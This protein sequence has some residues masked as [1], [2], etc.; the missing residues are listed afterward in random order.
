MGEPST[1]QEKDAAPKGVLGMMS[2]EDQQNCVEALKA[3]LD[4][5]ECDPHEFQEGAADSLKKTLSIFKYQTHPS[6]VYLKEHQ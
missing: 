5:V 6:N 4:D 3:L 2:N 1:D